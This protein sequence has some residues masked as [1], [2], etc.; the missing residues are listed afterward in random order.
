MRTEYARAY[1]QDTWGT[2]L[3]ESN[4]PSVVS[5]LVGAED[6]GNLHPARVRLLRSVGWGAIE[7]W[8]RVALAS[9][10]CATL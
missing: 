10:V 2:T 4:D 6:H 9:Q 5:R 8:R 1:S 7:G 3:G